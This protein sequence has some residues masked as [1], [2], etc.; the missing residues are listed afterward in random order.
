MR[1]VLYNL[2]NIRPP[3]TGIGR[4][5]VEVVRGGLKVDY[6]MAAMIRNQ[7]YQGETLRQELAQLRAKVS[8]NTASLRKLAGHVPMS[9]D[10]YRKTNNRRFEALS[11]TPEHEHALYHDLNYAPGYRANA[12]V[13]TIYDVSHRLHADTH[14]QHRVRFLERL[15]ADLVSNKQTI[16]TIS[17][18]VKTELIE[19][20]N[21]SPDRIHVT[22]LAAD[23]SF[24]PYSE[25]EF[26]ARAEFERL[27]YKGYVLCVA[28]L[29]PRKNLSRVL[30][31]YLAMSKDLQSQ[32]PLVIAGTAGWKAGKLER[33]IARL[34]EQGLII[35]MGFVAETSLP[36]LYAGAA[37]F[38]YP[39][40]YEGFGLPLL[41]AMQSGCP[42]ITSNTGALAELSAGNTCEVDPLQVEEIS[43]AIKEILQNNELADQYA[44]NGLDRAR[45]FDWARTLKQTHQV[46]QLV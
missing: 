5:A 26:A 42:A 32:Y 1:K 36:F 30:D 40:L 12:G 22:P 41:E 33:R 8:S 24:R 27:R 6:P 9:R 15:F 29:E 34:Q 44:V 46:Y 43:A 3:L 35:K 11:N 2:S 13:T 39:S 16:I 4:Y 14:P 28:T 21:M 23:Q 7:L 10:Y 19:Y 18:A 17:N 45:D 31:A 38:V 25:S 20:Y 37:V